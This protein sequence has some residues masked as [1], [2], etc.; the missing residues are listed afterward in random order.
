MHLHSGCIAAR[1]GRGP[2]YLL[3]SSMQRWRPSRLPLCSE[4]MDAAVARLQ[5]RFG[6]GERLASAL[7]ARPDNSVTPVAAVL[8]S[9]H[10]MGSSSVDSTLHEAVRRSAQWSIAS[11]NTDRDYA[12]LPGVDAWA[13]NAD[14]D[15]KPK[16]G[17]VLLWANAQPQYLPALVRGVSSWR[18]AI[19]V[20]DPR[21]VLISGAAFHAWTDEPAPAMLLDRRWMDG[22]ST[23][24][25]ALRGADGHTRLRM[26]MEW[27]HEAILGACG[28]I[29]LRHPSFQVY[30][31]EDLLQHPE[32][33]AASM[34][35]WLWPSHSDRDI[36]ETFEQLTASKFRMTPEQLAAD[37]ERQYRAAAAN[38]TGYGVQRTVRHYSRGATASL[39]RSHSVDLWDERN[40]RLFCARYG[41]ALKL[42]GSSKAYCW[43]CVNLS[44][45][46]HEE[47]K[48]ESRV[49]SVGDLSWRAAGS[50]SIMKQAQPSARRRVR[51]PVRSRVVRD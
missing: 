49:S 33:V 29:L 36:R 23:Y 15:G 35:S 12:R 48:D 27:A 3:V 32:R 8:A 18:G 21:D 9:F 25:E 7:S 30:R 14:I 4:E 51:V 37:A 38:R 50:R 31:F 19:V 41:G 24:R 10:K 2:T 11:A 39:R 43:S 40:R 17:S 42:L 13:S 44:V 5:E 46:R 22:N 16:R 6:V 20:R 28:L 47:C 1:E 45:T 26:E 34:S